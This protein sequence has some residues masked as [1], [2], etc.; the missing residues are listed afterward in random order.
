M[1]PNAGGWLNEASSRKPLVMG[2]V[3]FMFLPPARGRG[4][5]RGRRRMRNP[6]SQPLPLAGERR[7]KTCWPKACTRYYRSAGS[8][9]E[10]IMQRRHFLQAGAVAAA[11]LAAPAVHGQ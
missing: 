1:S 4:E 11:G 7:M 9:R 10:G 6:L 2:K 3:S 5:E 8:Q